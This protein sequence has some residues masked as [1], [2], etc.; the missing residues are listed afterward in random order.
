MGTLEAAVLEQVWNE[1]AGL[2]PRQVLDRLDAEL[3]Y[4]TV[5]TILNRLMAKGLL[6]RERHGRAFRYRPL[7]SQSEVVASRMAQALE[8]A[9][10]REMTLSRFVEGLPDGDEAFLRSLMRGKD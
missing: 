4:T 7:V 9:S 6:E 8:V 1:P 10:D 5:M 3:A 2:T